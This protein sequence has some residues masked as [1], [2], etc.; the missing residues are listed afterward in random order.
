MNNAVMTFEGVNQP[1]MRIR[2]CLYS[3]E[4]AAR[5]AP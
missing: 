3:L 1:R 4:P 2:C 5:I